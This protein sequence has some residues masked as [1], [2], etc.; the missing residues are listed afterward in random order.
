[1]ANNSEQTADNNVTV[2]AI[3]D[4]LG[5]LAQ[6]L[7]NL[8]EGSLTLA[9]I[10]ARLSIKSIAHFLITAM[11][12]AIL[13]V[14]LWLCVVGAF[15]YAVALSYSPWYGL[16]IFSGINLLVIIYCLHRCDCLS[17]RI[18][19]PRT[20]SWLAA[21]LSQH[22]AP[23]QTSVNSADSIAKDKSGAPTC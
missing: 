4:R 1:M 3:T 7:A 20:L 2:A 10:E 21:L 14:M 23:Q 6:L 19:F 15:C 16:L 9:E 22:S 18:G 13:A 5:N 12:C 11:T 17:A 8:S